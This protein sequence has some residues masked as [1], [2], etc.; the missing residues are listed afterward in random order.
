MCKTCGQIKE[1]KLFT[2][3]TQTIHKV[4]HRFLCC[5]Q[6]NLF[7]NFSV[8]H[9]KHIELSTENALTNNNNYIDIYIVVVFILFDKIVPNFKVI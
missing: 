8:L 1:K 7:S 6:G 5:F 2:I 3:H 4:I 9:V